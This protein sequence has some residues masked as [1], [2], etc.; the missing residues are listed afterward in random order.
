MVERLKAVGEAELG[1]PGCQLAGKVLAGPVRAI[2]RADDRLSNGHRNR[3]GAVRLRSL[4]RDRQV[5]VGLIVI[6]GTHLR[7]TLHYIL[8]PF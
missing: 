7:I 6:P 5:S 2:P 1:T 4:N 8:S 3:L